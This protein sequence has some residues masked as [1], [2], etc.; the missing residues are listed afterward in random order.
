MLCDLPV[1]MAVYAP[2][3][4]LHWQYHP[5]LARTA[6]LLYQTSDLD[7]RTID[8][9][10]GTDKVPSRLP[11]KQGLIDDLGM[12]V[13]AWTRVFLIFFSVRFYLGFRSLSN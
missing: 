9:A 5:Q 1:G 2:K 13:V 8:D 12:N 3:G 11:R 7:L 6:K 10:L 4:Y